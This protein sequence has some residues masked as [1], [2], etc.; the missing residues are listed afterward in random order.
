MGTWFVLIAKSDMFRSTM[1]D[2]T[3]QLNACSTL[4]GHV[5]VTRRPLSQLTF[6][7]ACRS[8]SCQED[9]SLCTPI[10]RASVGP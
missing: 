4:S 10:T 9:K 5:R 2:K 7:I 8:Y 6:K 1:S 3:R